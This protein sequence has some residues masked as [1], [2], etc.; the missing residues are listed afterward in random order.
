[1]DRV[2]LVGEF[3]PDLSRGIGKA[4]LVAHRKVVILAPQFSQGYSPLPTSLPAASF[5]Q[6]ATMLSRQ[7]VTHWEKCHGSS[8]RGVNQMLQDK[9]AAFQLH[10]RPLGKTLS[11][12][13]A[14]F[15]TPG[16]SA[17][18]SNSV[19]IFG[20]DFSLLYLHAQELS[21]DTLND[22]RAKYFKIAGGHC[23]RRPW[24]DRDVLASIKF[25]LQRK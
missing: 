24:L 11:A 7:L 10:P 25:V 6:L 3:D 4:S 18:G 19:E 8:P 21:N 13:L 16:E 2:R 17:P 15:G 12:F 9:P 20:W 1:M 22:S 14:S 23:D 5:C